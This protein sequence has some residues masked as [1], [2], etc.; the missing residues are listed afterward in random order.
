MNCVFWYG[1]STLH[2]ASFITNCYNLIAFSEQMHDWISLKLYFL[3]KAWVDFHGTLGFFSVPHSHSLQHPST[4]PPGVPD[5]PLWYCFYRTLT[6]K[7]NRGEIEA[8]FLRKFQERNSMKHCLSSPLLMPTLLHT[9]GGFNMHSAS[10]MT[11]CF[12]LHELRF[13][14]ARNVRLPTELHSLSKCMTGF[15]WNSGFFLRSS[16]PLSPTSEHFTSRFSGKA[17]YVSLLQYA[18]VQVE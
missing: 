6:S 18:N 1:G 13:P 4:L 10:V 7:W 9:R 16:F 8:A 3:S 17:P 5:K 12:Y 11:N 2:G 15:A 14:Y